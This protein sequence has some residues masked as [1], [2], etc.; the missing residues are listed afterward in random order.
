VP[1]SGPGGSAGTAP[2]GSRDGAAAQCTTSRLEIW[3]GVGEDDAS[4]DVRYPVEFT[5]VSRATCMLDGYPSVSV[6]GAAGRQI[7][8]AAGLDA[9]ATVRR[10]LLAP[11]A[12]AH[13]EGRFAAV[14]HFPAARCRPVAVQ[15]L[16]VFPPGQP[17]AEYIH[18]A[19]AA[20][21]AAGPKA[22]VFL[23]VQAIQQ[24]TGIP[25]HFGI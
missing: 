1:R 6:Y 23:N 17:V 12:T 8:N 25:G 10:I 5:N 3:L 18:Y 16:R 13:T 20:C 7:G 15:E 24:G 22:P 19:F 14:G 4:G 9:S 21:S 11:G 2:A